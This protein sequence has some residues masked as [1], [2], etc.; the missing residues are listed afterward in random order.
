MWNLN[1]I[2]VRFS[3]DNS[4]IHPSSIENNAITDKPTDYFKWEE[5]FTSESKDILEIY[6]IPDGKGSNVIRGIISFHPPVTESEH[7]IDKEGI[8]KVVNTDGGVLLGKMSFQMTADVFDTSWFQLVEDSDDS[9]TTG[10]KINID[11]TKY[12]EEPST[13]RFTDEI[14]SKDATL[15]ELI[16]SSRI[17]GQEDKKY[18]LTPQFDKDK[19]NYEVTLLEAIDTMKIKVTNSNEKSTMKIKVPKKE[20]DGTTI[21]YEEKDIQNNV[22]I[23]FVLNQLGEPDTRVT[24]EVTAEDG[25]TIKEYVLVI[26]RPYGTIKGKIVT[27]YTV[28]TTGENIATVFAYKSSDVASLFDWDEKQKAFGGKAGVDTVNAELHSLTEM[29]NMTTKADGTF[30]LHVIPGTYDILIDKPGYLDRIY[31]YV[32]VEEAETIDF[33]TYSL[34]AG[35]INKD[36][37]IQIQDIGLLS[38]HNGEDSSMN[39]FEQKYDLNDDGSVQIKDIGILSAENGRIREIENYKGR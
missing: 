7:I 31:I 10:I 34:V 17:E 25:K 14:I 26:K 35:D 28:S 39:G 18:E 24:I 20:A 29:K 22:P 32:T 1:G 13:F 8:G 27:P 12:Y 38:M 30:E 16:L 3:Y 11:G 9:P 21:I 5:E 2:D 23:E 6:T 33:G 36:A 4:K 15:S 37:I 19:F